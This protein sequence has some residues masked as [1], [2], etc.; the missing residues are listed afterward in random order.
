VQQTRD[1]RISDQSSE[2]LDERRQ[3]VDKRLAGG[4]RIS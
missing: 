3:Q 1:Q 2:E 4:L